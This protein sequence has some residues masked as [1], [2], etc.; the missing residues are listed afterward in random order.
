MNK[1]IGWGLLLL[2]Q[3]S[4]A[5]GQQDRILHF[6]AEY[7]LGELYVQ[8]DSDLQNGLWF[9]PFYDVACWDLLA[10]ATGDVSVPAGKRVTLVVNQE[11]W[12]KPEML[13]PLQDLDPNDLYALDLSN[14]WP[15]VG[16]AT[17]RC[18]PYIQHL[19]GLRQLNLGDSAITQNGLK[20][21]SGMVYLER[22]VVPEY[23]TNGG[24]A[25]LVQM[26]SL[27]SIRLRQN[28]IS[29]NAFALLADLPNLKE[30]QLLGDNLTDEGLACLPQ[31]THLEF[32]LLGAGKGP[33]STKG[34]AYIS[35][36]PNLR[37]LWIDS[38]DCADEKLA[39]LTCHPKLEG[40][41]LCWEGGITNQG[42]DCIS[43]I[44]NLKRLDISGAKITDRSLQT[45][46]ACRQLEILKLPSQGITDDGMRHLSRLARLK[47]LKAATCS[48]SPL[49]D[50][51]LADIAKLSH[52][53]KLWIAGNGFTDAGMNHLS[54]ARTLK[55]L[56]IG[57]CPS[58]TEEGFV[59][60]AKLENL[61]TLYWHG[62][63]GITFEGLNQFGSHKKLKWFECSDI[64]RGK[65]ALNLSGMEN[66]E[67]LQI[68]M[69]R[70]YN[71]NARTQTFQDSFVDDDLA[72]LAGLEKLNFIQL[73][74]DGIGDRGLEY[75]KDLD[76]LGTL[77]LEGRSEIT[78]EG[79]RNLSGMNRLWQLHIKDGHF[80]EEA[81]KMLA[82]M[83]SLAIIELRT[84]R[85]MSHQ[86]IVEF[87]Q[88][89]KNLKKWDLRTSGEKP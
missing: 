77:L 88:N 48:G 26:K 53:E 81:L 45:L 49:T 38:H 25:T 63:S 15:P 72:C 23:L 31:L 27:T 28:R 5:A 57:F 40:L 11:A 78:D 58:V 59:N 66:L 83:D 67:H 32:L 70:T 85:H 22:I 76:R 80:T 42:I 33:F 71:K 50:R 14:A 29:D 69:P 87:R 43:Q 35:Q 9:N 46:G 21:L 68:E 79:I 56:L 60:L 36:I 1:T 89:K 8:D 51:S 34:Y 62:G 64:R 20:K 74:G 13:A 86:A 61:E 55:E 30:L 16:P 44:P 39:Q 3:I 41:D 84:D 2:V 52:L 37:T 6:P 17:D 54:N 10:Q 24:L 4:W 47:E 19:T 75:L 82:G 12:Q 65:V 7:S 73:D 18:I